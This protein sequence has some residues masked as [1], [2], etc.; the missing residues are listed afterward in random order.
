MSILA[1]LTGG[2]EGVE[3]C[4]VSAA[5]EDN[6]WCVG[7]QLGQ[8]EP[9]TQAETSHADLQITNFILLNLFLID[10]SLERG[11]NRFSGLSRVLRS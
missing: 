10:G 6:A 5:V 9:D 8:E 3:G 1:V 7:A 4:D 11:L 2:V